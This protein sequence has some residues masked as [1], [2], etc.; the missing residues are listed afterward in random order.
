MGEE[1]KRN[2]Y[3]GKVSDGDDPEISAIFYAVKR[4]K[5]SEK[6]CK[7]IALFVEKVMAELEIVVEDDAQLNREGQPAVN[8]L[9]KLPLLVEV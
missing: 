1:K 9:R 3:R 8:K 2:R 6:S 5:K 4:R 7:E